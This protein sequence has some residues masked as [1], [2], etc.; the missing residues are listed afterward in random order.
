MSDLDIGRLHTFHLTVGDNTATVEFSYTS[1]QGKLVRKRI[2][3]NQNTARYIRY[4]LLKEAGVSPLHSIRSLADHFS[5]GK[6]L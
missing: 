4:L 1:P 3:A 2:G 6:Q 5:E